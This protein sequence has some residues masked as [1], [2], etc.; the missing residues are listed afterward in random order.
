MKPHCMF[1]DEQYSEQWYRSTSVQKFVDE[2][3][4]GLVV[5]GT[6]LQTSLAK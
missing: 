1:F 3:M 4:D 6:A 5:I 2:K